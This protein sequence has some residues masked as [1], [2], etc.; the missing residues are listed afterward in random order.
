[1]ETS[2][3]PTPTLPAP[4][5]EDCAVIELR[6]YTLH[7]GRRD[8][9]IALFE[10]EFIEAQEAHGM[11]VIAQFRDRQRPDHFVWL[12]GFADMGSRRSALEGFYGGAVWAAHREAAN[13]TMV[14]S[15]DVRLLRPAKPSWALTTPAALRPRSDAEADGAATSLFVLTL[16]ALQVAPYAAF[17]RFFERE[18][19]PLLRDAGAMPI[20]VFETEAALNDYPRLPVRTDEQVF[21]WLARVPSATAWEHAERQL[22]AS[23]AWREQV[24]P[25]FSS[26]ATRAPITRQLQPTARS[27]LR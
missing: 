4:A 25:R 17:R 3:A 16:C 9:L 22:A 1:M 24:L 2:L 21:A 8:E 18:A 6:D 27:W 10:R 23:P 20:A 5:L 12:R 13:A 14:D 11:R 26:A 7:P 15:D 19:L